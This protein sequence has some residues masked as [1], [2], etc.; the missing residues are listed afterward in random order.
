MEENIIQSQPANSIVGVEKILQELKS[1][2]ASKEQMLEGLKK[3]LQEGKLSQE[4]FDKALK[5]IEE[6]EEDKEEVEKKEASSLFG[7]EL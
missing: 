3:L 4:D 6:S 2:G 1:K 7:V 5:L